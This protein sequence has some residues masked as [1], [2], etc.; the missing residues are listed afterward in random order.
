MKNLVISSGGIN[1]LCLLG[2]LKYL[3]ENN[4]LNNIKCYFGCSAGAIL[5][6]MLALDYTLDEMKNFFIQS[7]DM[8]Y[9]FR[10]YKLD[11]ILKMIENE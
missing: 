2:S 7:A 6:T 4:L 9:L 5:T 11:E 1:L 10:N 3:N 8:S